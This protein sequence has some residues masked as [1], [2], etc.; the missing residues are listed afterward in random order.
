MTYC[1]IVYRLYCI[2]TRFLAMLSGRQA[3]LLLYLSNADYV[4]AKESCSG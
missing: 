3:E 2:S 4:I 1:M